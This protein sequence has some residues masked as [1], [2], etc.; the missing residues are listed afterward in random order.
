MLL[1]HL[2]S[3]VLVTFLATGTALAQQTPGPMRCSETV[4]RLDRELS[5]LSERQEHPKN[6]QTDQVASTPLP[7]SRVLAELMEMVALRE[8]L[9]CLGVDPK[10]ERNR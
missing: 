2:G 10:G 7:A 3:T 1:P 8:H 4:K 5:A 9:R 6:L